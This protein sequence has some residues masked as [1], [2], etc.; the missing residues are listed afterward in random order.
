MLTLSGL[1]E[2]FIRHSLPLSN[3]ATVVGG[4]NYNGARHRNTICQEG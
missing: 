1:E 4:L 2:P 3:I